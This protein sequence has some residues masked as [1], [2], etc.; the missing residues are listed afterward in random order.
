[1]FLA[2]FIYSSSSGSPF[3]RVQVLVDNGVVEVTLS[4]P[5]GHITGIRYNGER[6]L[7]HYAG[8]D[9]SGGY[10]KYCINSSVVRLIHMFPSKLK[11]RQSMIMYMMQ[12]L[13]C[14]VELSR[15][16]SPKRDDRHVS[17]FPCSSTQLDPHNIYNIMLF[18]TCCP[19]PWCVCVHHRH[20]IVV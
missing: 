8:E 17:T 3:V 14:G 2:C 13:G 7:L 10:G 16:R 15:L 12:V 6:N 9:N 20:Y 19:P 18:F 4:K 5:Q 11:W 1:M